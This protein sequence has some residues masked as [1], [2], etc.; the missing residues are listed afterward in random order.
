[1]NMPVGDVWHTVGMDILQLPESKRGNKYLLVLH[2]YYS[3]WIEVYPMKDQMV[4]TVVSNLIDICSRFGFPEVVHSDQGPNF[5]SAMMKNGLE[6]FGVKKTR[7]TSYH[8]QGNG[9]VERTNRTIIQM[10][11]TYVDRHHDWEDGLPMLLHAYHMSRHAATGVSPYLL[12]FGREAGPLPMYNVQ[13]EFH[14]LPRDYVNECLE[15]TAR[16]TRFV[17]AHIAKAQSHQK[18]VYDTSAKERDSLHS[19]DSVLLKV[20]KQDKLAPK[21]ETEWKVD[22]I[23]G[24]STVSILHEDGKRRVVHVNRLQI[25]YRNRPVSTTKWNPPTDMHEYEAITVP[26]EQASATET[27]TT[28]TR[29]SRQRLKPK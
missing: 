24:P 17:D 3:K 19:G 23:I 21:W 15:R 14:M 9:L 22:E 26:L 29:P 11:S 25:A 10:L 1:M 6:A 4:E 2:D 27:A 28:T 12:M 20:P 8:P 5:E 7:T 13:P 18:K 16:V